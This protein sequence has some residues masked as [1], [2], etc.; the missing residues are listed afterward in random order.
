MPFRSQIYEFSI[1]NNDVRELVNIGES[2]KQLDDGWAEQRY[3]MI[4]A[5]NEDQARKEALRRFPEKN[6]FVYTS[7]IK[8]Q[9]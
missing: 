6:G 3:I 8:F 7:V 4:R 5:L 1:Y 9:E 2:H